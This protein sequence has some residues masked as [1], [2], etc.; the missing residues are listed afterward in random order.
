M[1]TQNKA[2]KIGLSALLALN[3]YVLITTHTQTQDMCNCQHETTPLWEQ[4]ID[5]A[6]TNYSNETGVPTGSYIVPNYVHFVMFN[7]Q[8]ITYIQM[9]CF[10]AAFKNQ[11]PDK[12][13]FHRNFNSSFIGKYWEVLRNTKGF[14][15][16]VVFNYV[17]IPTEIF[18]QPLDPSNGFSIYHAADVTR[19]Q[20]LMKF[21]GIILDSDTYIINNLNQ[22]RVFEFTLNWDENQYLGCQLLIAHRDSRFLKLYLETYR[23]AYK[24][25][26]WY[27]NFG[28]RP[29]TEIL[30]K[31]PELIHRVKVLFGADTKFIGHLFQRKWEDWRNFF[32]VHLLANHQYLLHN[33]TE[34]A[35][36]PV[37][38]NE[39]NIAY[40]PVTF[41][42]MAYNVYDIA[43]IPWPKEY[44][45]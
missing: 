14:M 2:L 29:T 45:D 41:R 23:N 27:Y 20:V 40:Y 38:F 24:P 19:L 34:K 39:T 26:L 10:L 25:H 42:E 32:A 15:D 4:S 1:I 3:V 36:F 21:G 31:Q 17:P 12:F 9:I 35:T 8:E 44:K 43:G 28:E 11:K 5:F 6:K 30:Y 16:I 7:V 33:L 13:F 18:G 22:F 37:K